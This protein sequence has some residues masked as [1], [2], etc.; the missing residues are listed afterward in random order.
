MIGLLDVDDGDPIAAVSD[1]GIG[2]RHRDAPG[3]SERRARAVEHYGLHR[4]GDVDDIEAGRVGDEEI[5]E[6]H[7]GSWA[8]AIGMTDITLG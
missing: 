8:P 7:I 4:V 1:I 6:L 3:V 2:A 5:A